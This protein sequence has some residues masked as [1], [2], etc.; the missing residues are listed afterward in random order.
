MHFM[1]TASYK[2]EKKERGII[3]ILTDFLLG[4]WKNITKIFQ[5]SNIIM[6]HNILLFDM[7]V[8]LQQPFSDCK[9]LKL[10]K[11]YKI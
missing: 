8:S 1:N 2:L 9:L 11:L 4:S 10:Q 6:I 3:T 5:Y 7:P